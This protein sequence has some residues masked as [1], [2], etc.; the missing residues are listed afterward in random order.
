M[1][2]E[3]YAECATRAMGFLK[4]F[5]VSKTNGRNNFLLRLSELRAE[6]AAVREDLR[7]HV[8]DR[9]APIAEA[10]AATQGAEHKR[11]DRPGC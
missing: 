4:N 7:C 11:I 1:E 6:L 8:R 3:I 9:V 5:N 2:R 10:G